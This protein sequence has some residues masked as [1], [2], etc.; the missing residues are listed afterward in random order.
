L[1][2]V[3]WGNLAEVI[4]EVKGL[5]WFQILPVGQ[6]AS[7]PYQFNIMHVIP[8]SKLPVETLPLDLLI[9]NAISYNRKTERRGMATSA[10]MLAESKFAPA[11]KPDPAREEMV[12]EALSQGLFMLPEYQFDHCVYTITE[13]NLTEEG[14]IYGYNKCAAFLRLK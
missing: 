1:S 11:A 14:L 12:K 3:E 13:N 2:G 10:N 9:N 4:N 6:K 7:Q 5:G 8:S